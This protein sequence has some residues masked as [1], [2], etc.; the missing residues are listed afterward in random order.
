MCVCVCVIL[1]INKYNYYI[2]NAM[3]INPYH[4]IK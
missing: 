2:G 3:S 4:V 1:I